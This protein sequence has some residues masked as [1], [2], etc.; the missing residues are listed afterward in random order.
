VI[1]ATFDYV[2]FLI[3]QVHEK[4][5]RAPKLRASTTLAEITLEPQADAF[6]GW[7]AD[8]DDLENKTLAGLGAAAFP[9][10]STDNAITRWD[11]T[12]G[13]SLQNSAVTI[14]DA[15]NIALLALATV[16]GRDVS[17]DGASLDATVI[18]LAATVITLNATVVT[19]SSTV[20][21]VSSFAAAVNAFNFQNYR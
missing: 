12:S 15:G 20:A 13:T 21:T 1:E 9:V 6:L 18:T 3:Q 19:L 5:L 14:N 10:S 17:V 11:G 4:V 7:N 2:T 8:G 16:D